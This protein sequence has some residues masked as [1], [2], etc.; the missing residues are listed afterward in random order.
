MQNVR[1]QNARMGDLTCNS[2]Q[3]GGAR[4]VEDGRKMYDSNDS[5]IAVLDVEI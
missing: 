4:V 3:V 1:Y 5:R 2:R